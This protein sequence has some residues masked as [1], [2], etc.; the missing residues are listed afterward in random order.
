MSSSICGDC[1]YYEDIYPKALEEIKTLEA[2]VAWQAELLQWAQ[3]LIML[4]EE[5]QRCD[6]SCF[7][8]SD[9]HGYEVKEAIA[10]TTQRY[11]E[12]LARSRE[13]GK[14]GQ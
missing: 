6:Q 14:E 9:G 13:L 12:V 10:D 2:K 8:T 11:Q 5:L 4:H 1:S 7:D 3:D